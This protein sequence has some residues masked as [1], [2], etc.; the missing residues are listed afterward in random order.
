MKL[1]DLQRKRSVEDDTEN[2]L[3]VQ[4]KERPATDDSVF[5]RQFYA[6]DAQTQNK[7][8]AAKQDDARKL[9]QSMSNL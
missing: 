1:G 2:E 5:N 4:T 3:A 6:P 9:G 7:S 8:V